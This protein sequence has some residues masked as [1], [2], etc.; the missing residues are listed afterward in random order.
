MN[1][2]LGHKT[3]ISEVNTMKGE[4]KKREREES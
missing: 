2:Y 4:E 1:A 3:T